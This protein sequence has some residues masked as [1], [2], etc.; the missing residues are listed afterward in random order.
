MNSARTVLSDPMVSGDRP[1]DFQP[2]HFG[3]KST[4]GI[5]FPFITLGAILK[6]VVM[7]Q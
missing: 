4:Q 5:M 7:V 2:N 6:L 1:S 3:S